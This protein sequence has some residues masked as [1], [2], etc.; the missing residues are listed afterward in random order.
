MLGQLLEQY[1]QQRRQGSLPDAIVPIPI[2]PKRYRERGHNQLGAITQGMSRPIRNRLQNIL[3]VS[4]TSDTKHQNANQRWSAANPFR[5]VERS[6]ARI[7]I[8]DDIYTTGS[9]LFHATEALRGA[10]AHYVEVWTV[11]RTARPGYGHCH[12]LNQG[13]ANNPR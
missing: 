10:G 7:A 4:S 8:L 12:W 13:S 6:P 2:S 5:C 11:A 1:L 3:A 9:T